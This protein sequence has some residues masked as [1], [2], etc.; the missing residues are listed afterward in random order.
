MTE[1]NNSLLNQWAARRSELEGLVA[2]LLNSPAVQRLRHV[3]FLGILSPRFR[4]AVPSPLWP[5]TAPIS[6]QDG[7]RLDHSIGVAL[8][9]LDVA[10]RLELSRRGERLAVAWGLTHDLAT[11]PLSH[12]SEP[13]FASTTGRSSRDLCMSMILGRD[14]APPRYR[15]H[16]ELQE[17]GIAPEELV[18]L[19]DREAGPLDE[20]ANLLWQLIHS[21]LTPDS[22]EGIW[23][24][25]VV[26][27]VPVPSPH[28][29][30]RGF[31]RHG[32]FAR[33][34][35]ACLPHIFDFWEGKRGVYTRFINRRDV[36][37]WE[38]AWSIAIQ[39]AFASVS[40][41]ESLDIPESKLIETVQ[42]HGLPAIT[43]VSRY[44][45]PLN[46]YVRGG[47]DTP[48]TNPRLSDLWQVLRREPLGSVTG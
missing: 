34:S 3:T 25:G 14:D 35:A 13:A 42:R 18:G 45:E 33:Y 37:L 32:G 9:A 28:E 36:V 17:L 24:C 27:G 29:V 6:E 47:F 22:L 38:S 43:A 31:S 11:W 8:T 12:T 20:D 39:R 15:V 5:Q 21:P 44:K 30:A 23:R 2:P 48:S 46:Y 41:A 4:G 26:L 1:A 40:L 7:T 19:I 10:R 16:A